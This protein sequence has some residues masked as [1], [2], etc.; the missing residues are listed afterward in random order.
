MSNTLKTQFGLFKWWLKKLVRT[1]QSY[2]PSLK[3]AKDRL[4]H[5]Y[6]RHRRTPSDQDFSAIR[7]FSHL[8]G[9]YVDIGANT[10]QS[11]E[12]I[13]LYASD[14]KIVSFE[15]NPE[16]AAM[17]SRRYCSDPN[18]TIRGVGLSDTVTKLNLHVPVYRGF[19]YDGLAS[20]DLAAARSWISS[21]TV[22]FFSPEDLKV[23]SYECPI[24]TLDMQEFDKPL[25]IKMDVEGLELQVIKG[26]VETLRKHEPIIMVE[27]LYDK[28]ELAQLAGDLGFKS[29]HFA[30]GRFVSGFSDQNRNTFLITE[31][32]MALLPR[33]HMY[34]GG[35]LDEQGSASHR[36]C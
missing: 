8:P 24:E 19:V 34:C 13:K 9:I 26:G 20:M 30:S 18:V 2:F 14:A 10:G 36:A 16:L 28:P 23:R 21:E 25:F 6:R 22:Y 29:Y 12:S 4:Y 31:R 11:I 1:I 33:R 7:L 5:S 27:S 17:L 3:E 35:Q 32:R 15:P